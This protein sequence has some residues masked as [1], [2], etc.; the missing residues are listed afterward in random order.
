MPAVIFSQTSPHEA[1]SIAELSG[2]K[3]V[4]V[5]G[6]SDY[7]ASVMVAVLKNPYLV[8]W[9]AE[10]VDIESSKISA[11]PI[12]LNGFIHTRVMTLYLAEVASTPAP[13]PTNLLMVNFGLTHGSRVT[14]YDHFC[15][16]GKVGSGVNW[17]SCVHKANKT[18]SPVGDHGENDWL[19]L[20]Y[21]TLA[22]YKYILCPRGNGIDTHR[23]YEALAIGVIPIIELGQSRAMD[24]MYSSLPILLVQSFANITETLLDEHLSELQ[25][26][27]QAWSLSMW[28][29]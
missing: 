24:Q 23:V 12:G 11:I 20:W 19:I 9:F 28:L 6:S 18:T 5:T 22:A 13:A 16:D 29:I 8:H 1:A 26:R 17:A 25:P 2:Q 21:R 27:V 10:N 7:P 4:L 15:G 14:V 3:F